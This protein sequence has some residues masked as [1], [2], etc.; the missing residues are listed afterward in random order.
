MPAF[1]PSKFIERMER[2]QVQFKNEFS[3]F[4]FSFSFSNED[5]FAVFSDLADTHGLLKIGGS[6]YHGKQTQ[7]ESDL[8]S[9]DLPVVQIHRFLKVA[10]PTWFKAIKDAIG[11]YG[12]DPSRE[13]LERLWGFGDEKYKAKMM[14]VSPVEAIELSLA[15]WLAPDERN[16]SEIEDLRLKL[17]GVV[18]R[19][20]G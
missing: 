2:W 18:V 10:R 8:G 5:S 11:G 9:I 20:D 17:R 19:A 3:E 13:N 7:V 6:D 14:M 16:C 4:L 12:D 15:S 1:M